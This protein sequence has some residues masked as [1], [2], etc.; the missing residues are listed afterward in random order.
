MGGVYI[1]NSNYVY[2]GVN[3]KNK[4]TQQIITDFKL[5]SKNR[6]YI[7]DTCAYVKNGKVYDKDD[8]LLTSGYILDDDMGLFTKLKWN[9]FSNDSYRSI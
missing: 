5:D 3:A 6:V 2:D 4:D 9:C 1:Y 8:N 7:V